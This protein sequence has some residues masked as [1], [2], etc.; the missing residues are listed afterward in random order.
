[1]QL[2]FFGFTLWLGA[3][4]LARASYNRTVQFTGWGLLAYALALGIHI[5][6]A[7]FFFILL[8]IP[9]LLWIGAALH[10]LPEEDP[11]RN[12][13]IRTWAVTAIP[14]AILTQINA[15]F[16]AIVVLCLLI[17]AGM[18]TRLAFRSRYK[19]TYALLAVIALFVALSSGLLILLSTGCR[20]T[21]VS[22]CLASTCSSSASS[23]PH[24]MPSTKARRFALISSA[25]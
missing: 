21:G 11:H 19:N 25:R 13:Y 1:M 18:V 3:Y 17:S 14:L 10:L 6:T 9:A 4:L 2:F 20:S 7:Q 12:T 8:L 15:W 23:S 22:I 5:L 24:S 16:S